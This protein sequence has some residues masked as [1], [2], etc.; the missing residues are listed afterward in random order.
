MDNFSSHS[1]KS[2]LE[3]LLIKPRGNSFCVYTAAGD[4][5]LGCGP[6]REWA[7]FRIANIELARQQM[8]FVKSVAD[9]YLQAAELVDTGAVNLPADE[10]D[11]ASFLKSLPTDYTSREREEILK[12]MTKH[13]AGK[14]DQ[15][16][17]AGDE[18]PRLSVNI[19]PAELNQLVD[20][21]ARSQASKYIQAKTGETVSPEDLPKSLKQKASELKEAA[22]ELDSSIG[23]VDAVLDAPGKMLSTARKAK[24]KLAKAKDMIGK[25]LRSIVKPAKAAAEVARAAESVAIVAMAGASAY[26]AWSRYKANKGPTPPGLSEPEQIVILPAPKTGKSTNK[27]AVTDEAIEFL[28]NF[29][30]FCVQFGEFS[31]EVAE[32]SEAGAVDAAVANRCHQLCAAFAECA[33]SYTDGAKLGISNMNKTHVVNLSQNTGTTVEK[34]LPGMHEQRSHAGQRGHSSDDVQHN[35]EDGQN[36][37]APVDAVD[38]LIEDI[39][40]K[41]RSGERLGPE[42]KKFLENPNLFTGNIP[43]T[44]V[45]RSNRAR[46]IKLDAT[47]PDSPAVRGTVGV[48]NGVMFFV[49]ENGNEQVLGPSKNMQ[50]LP[51]TRGEARARGRGLGTTSIR[52]RAA[53]ETVT[54]DKYGNKE[55]KPRKLVRALHAFT[56]KINDIR[57]IAGDVWEASSGI[58]NTVIRIA[59]TASNLKT[60]K[61]MVNDGVVAVNDAV[62]KLNYELYTLEQQELAKK[63]VKKARTEEEIIPNKV[64]YSYI[65]LEA[66]LRRSISGLRMLRQLLNKDMMGNSEAT[67]EDREEFTLHIRKLEELEKSIRQTLNRLAVSV[68]AESVDKHLPGMHEQGTHASDKKS[69]AVLDAARNKLAAVVASPTATVVQ[70]ASTQ[71]VSPNNFPGKYPIQD[72]FSKPTQ[73]KIKNI[74]EKVGKW[75]T[76]GGAATLA[77]GGA[78]GAS[79]VLLTNA[80]KVPGTVADSART[81]EKGVDNLR[82]YVNEKTADPAR[83]NTPAQQASSN[84]TN[85]FMGFEQALDAER[86]RRGEQK[87]ETDE[88]YDFVDTAATLAD[89]I[90]ETFSDLRELGRVMAA[91]GEI[92]PEDAEKQYGSDTSKL[93]ETSKRLRLLCADLKK[94][95]GVVAKHLPGQHN[96]DTH[97]GYARTAKKLKRSSMARKLFGKSLGGKD[98][99]NVF[100]AKDRDVRL[101]EFHDGTRKMVRSSVLAKL[102]Y[103]KASG[104]PVG[105]L[106]SSTA[107]LH[108]AGFVSFAQAAYMHDHNRDMFYR[109]QSL[110][111]SGKRH[112][113]TTTNRMITEEK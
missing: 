60:A 44:E 81:L 93:E 102:A 27:S 98:I 91:S 53:E 54:I 48:K 34:H 61:R 72:A 70:S 71:M 51:L 7:V 20:I 105:K 4:R 42:E 63:E 37:P 59:N 52:H 95:D 109:I 43:V 84:I 110:A 23:A 30:A 28:E 32:M 1:A 92:S 12:V 40:H 77:V 101:V 75:A 41:E 89:R 10:A 16:N 17:H 35:D 94:N 6:N 97:A 8:G 55:V 47:D 80:A 85:G 26:T 11:L 62:A 50:E 113:D 66:P 9:T 107:K 57:S 58:Y 56:D 49:D 76:I 112:W 36:D 106:F 73:D 25:F 38:A 33:F 111:K 67:A 13:L 83:T 21:R 18:T 68:T 2:L 64:L 100:K 78:L 69:G 5:N 87:S 29:S 3:K 74:I 103:G 90:V 19:S 108:K 31:E 22:F 88:D 24:V 79:I 65:R 46:V 15:K 45:A 14:H 39:K 104:H 96:Q 99:K 86:K 82:R